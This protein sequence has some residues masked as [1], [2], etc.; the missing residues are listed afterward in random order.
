MIGVKIGM[1]RR[2][3]WRLRGL[4]YADELVLCGESEEDAR[5]KVGRLLRCVG[6]EV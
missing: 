5:A 3:E 4:L 6:E 2:E 1:G